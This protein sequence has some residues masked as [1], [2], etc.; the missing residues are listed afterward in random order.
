MTAPITLEEQVDDAI[1]AEG[2]EVVTGAPRSFALRVGSDRLI[3]LPDDL[4]EP[5]RTVEKAHELAHHATGTLYKC[6][7]NDRRVIGKCEETAFRWSAGLLL[8]YA[9]L[10]RAIKKERT[11]DPCA[12]GDIL[13]LPAEFVA[14]CEVL[15]FGLLGKEAPRLEN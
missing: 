4:P 10:V 8:P 3:C 2:V 12:L 1:V 6:G 15:Y 11:F 13:T 14:R 5:E 9:R 7:E